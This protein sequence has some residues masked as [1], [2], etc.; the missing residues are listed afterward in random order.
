MASPDKEK[1]PGMEYTYIYTYC[2]YMHT[3]N[4]YTCK[5][6]QGKSDHFFFSFLSL[7]SLE[8]EKTMRRKALATRQTISR[9]VEV[10]GG[11]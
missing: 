3:H 9:L 11:G 10:E 1:F 5:E 7:F 2:T 6:R 8:R 4:I